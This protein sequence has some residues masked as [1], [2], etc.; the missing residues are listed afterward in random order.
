[1]AVASTSYSPSTTD[2]PS[3]FSNLLLLPLS[4]FEPHINIS[5]NKIH[6]QPIT[7]SNTLH[8]QL[9]LILGG[10]PTLPDTN[11]FQSVRNQDYLK[12]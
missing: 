10:L 3:V 7:H 5:M 2:I 1:M 12:Y 9:L 11:L 6:I 4:S 8:L